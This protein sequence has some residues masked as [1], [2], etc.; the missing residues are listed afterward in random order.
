MGAFAANRC[1]VA[2]ELFC[3]VAPRAS[4][5]KINDFLGFFQFFFMSNGIT[6]IVYGTPIQVTDVPDI[7]FAA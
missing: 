2:V 1:A 4:A 3:Q 6:A 7:R 5:W